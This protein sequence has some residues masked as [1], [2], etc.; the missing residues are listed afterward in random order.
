[1]SN[2]IKEAIESADGCFEAALAEGI[3]DKMA[4]LPDCEEVYAFLDVYTRRIMHARLHIIEALQALEAQQSP[5]AHITTEPSE[6][7]DKLKGQFLALKSLS[8][9]QSKTISFYIDRDY[10]LSE[11]RLK[12]LEE[13]LQSERD[14]NA[15]LTEELE[16]QQIPVLDDGE[17][18]HCDFCG[19]VPIITGS[20]GR[21]TLHHACH[22]VRSNI[23]VCQRKDL[24]KAWNTRAQN[25]T[26]D[27]NEMVDVDG[28]K[29]SIRDV[30]CAPCPDTVKCWDSCI[31]HLH[32]QGHLKA[33]GNDDE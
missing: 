26:V 15:Q 18:L 13:S 32:E 10:S 1:M 22:A 11:Q 23:G 16:A 25:H 31:D 12:S 14:M 9:S 24:I 5:K 28:L 29:Y 2:E 4:N 6:D 19:E 7:Y 8:N 30:W 20:L 27:A 17:L 3:N 21:F 33:K